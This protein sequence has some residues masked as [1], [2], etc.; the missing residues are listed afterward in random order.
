MLS[1]PSAARWK[2]EG[3]VNGKDKHAMPVYTKIMH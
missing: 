1:E 3:W 2:D